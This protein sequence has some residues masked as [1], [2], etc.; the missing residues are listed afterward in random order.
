MKKS[1]YFK[2]FLI[3]NVKFE[4]DL[5]KSLKSVENAVSLFEISIAYIVLAYLK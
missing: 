4:L 1:L 2:K 3:R 5:W